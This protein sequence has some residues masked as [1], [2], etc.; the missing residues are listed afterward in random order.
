MYRCGYLKR[1][2]WNDNSILTTCLITDNVI[3]DDWC[4]H[5]ACYIDTKY[6]ID[7]KIF[8]VTFK[9][10]SREDYGASKNVLNY[11]Y[12]IGSNIA[13][14]YNKYDPFDVRM[15]LRSTNTLL[16][17]IIIFTIIG[18]N[19]LLAWIFYEVYHLYSQRNIEAQ[20]VDQQV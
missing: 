1:S 20:I 2:E 11:N 7:T 5:Y 10:C 18:V 3:T 19:I 4:C 9:V 17:F 6:V 15:N 13:C 14:F 12:A 16:I 8:N